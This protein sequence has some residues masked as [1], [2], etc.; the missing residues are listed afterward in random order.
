MLLL[1]NL[2]YHA[3][4]L[5]IKYIPGIMFKTVYFFRYV[6]VIEKNLITLRN[7]IAVNNFVICNNFRNIVQDYKKK[8]NKN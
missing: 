8:N 7:K 2:H 4:L 5:S 1:V 3:T 6:I